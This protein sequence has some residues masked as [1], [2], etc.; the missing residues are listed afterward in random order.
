MT[1]IEQNDRIVRM[2]HAAVLMEKHEFLEARRVYNQLLKEDPK[3]G[4]VWYERARL[5]QKLGS[6]RKAAKGYQMAIKL[7]DN[8]HNAYLAVADLYEF[9]LDQPLR[10][11]KI[12]LSGIE[13]A[14]HSKLYVRLGDFYR[15]QDHFAKAFH[16]YEQCIEK[17]PEEKLAC[18]GMAELFIKLKKWGKVQPLLE[19]LLNKNIEDERVYL[20]L[21]HYINY[22]NKWSNLQ[23]FLGL[24]DGQETGKSNR[25][26][27][28]AEAGR[29]FIEEMNWGD[30]DQGN[31]LGRLVRKMRI[32]TKQIS[33]FGAIIELYEMAIKLDNGNPYP[34]SR[35]AEFYEKFNLIEDAI[36]LL[37]KALKNKWDAQ[38]A[39]QLGM[40]FL[41]VED[42]QSA[43]ALFERQLSINPKD[44]HLRYLAACS[45]LELGNT[46]E[47]EYKLVRILED[48][49]YEANVHYKLGWL[50]N[51]Q[52]RYRGAKEI[53]EHG[54]LY[55]PFDENIKIQLSLALSC[56]DDH[57]EALRIINE[58]VLSE[59]GNL[60]A[61]YNKACYLA[62]LNRPSEAKCELDF[63]IEQDETG[64][65]YELALKDEDLKSLSMLQ[66]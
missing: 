20:M 22:V 10:V 31:A 55:H 66:G 58:V 52:R 7:K 18:L 43:L 42:F 62:L 19:L 4:H 15:E 65:Y 12:L 24:L 32:R 53:L 54:L 48:D 40:L 28:A 36:K 14:S 60:Q 37:Q 17:Y 39:Y 1:F 25:F 29:Q 11:E 6:F 38:L 13:A 34:I 57:E 64:Y 51:Q 2:N 41:Q 8:V 3:D 45:L 5:D 56:M 59:G 44:S 61:H 63:V 49:P 47:A 23:K 27:L 50:L 16:Y 21:V 33:A 26:L 35:F 30:E 9:E 46:G